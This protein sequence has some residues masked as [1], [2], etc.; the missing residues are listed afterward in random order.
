MRSD[1]LMGKA[2]LCGVIKYVR[3]RQWQELKNLVSTLKPLNF[4]FFSGEF[5]GL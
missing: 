3:I 2:L 4:M 1:Y 5:Y